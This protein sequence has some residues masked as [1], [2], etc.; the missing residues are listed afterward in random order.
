MKILLVS[1]GKGGVYVFTRELV[2][3]LS[4]RGHYILSLFVTGSKNPLKPL[5]PEMHS[6]FINDSS[7]WRKLV[8]LAGKQFDLIHTSFAAPIPF[9]SLSNRPIV[10]TCHGLPQ[11][12]LEPSLK[13]RA[14]FSV[15][16]T[17]LPIAFR[18]V[19]TTV[20]VSKFVSAQLKSLY[21]VESQVIYHGI[22]PRDFLF[23][24]AREKR[25][26]KRLLGI[27][28]QARVVL[29]VGRF[30]PYKDPMTLI[31]AFHVVERKLPKTRLILAGDG[32]LYSRML[33][34][35]KRLDLS[36][37]TGIYRRPSFEEIRLFYRAADVFV[38]PSLNEAFGMVILEAMA[39][40]VPCVVSDKGACAEILGKN[41]LIFA[42]GNYVDLAEKILR[43]LENENLRREFSSEAYDRMLKVFS[44]DVA[45]SEYEKIF[46]R[47]V[48]RD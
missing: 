19:T 14:L 2:R 40:G 9:L 44:W 48:N 21:N 24:G 36:R 34:T 8:E 30:H 5:P 16:K 37:K 23:A 38:L 15:E 13:Q 26:S 32:E 29:C 22:N 43:I 39:S 25:S 33:D 4:R 42:S 20:S 7:D 18:K 3:I 46:S 47:V 12:W 27:N 31:K 35:V 6:I 28:S 41:G 10:F 11:P 45:A 17:V 1:G